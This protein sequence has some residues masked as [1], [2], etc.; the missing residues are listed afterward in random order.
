MKLPKFK[1]YVPRMTGPSEH[2]LA[3][4]KVLDRLPQAGVV[5]M[6]RGEAVLA[7]VERLERD[8][9]LEAGDD[10]ILAPCE[11]PAADL[12]THGRLASARLVPNR[13]PAMRS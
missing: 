13:D 6:N 3:L 10:G 4:R 2:E 5:D 7:E 8:G 1:R 9:V 11:G 12:L